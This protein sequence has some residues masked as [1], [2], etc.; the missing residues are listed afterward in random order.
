[1]VL[2]NLLKELD[3]TDD[4]A[5]D[6]MTVGMTLKYSNKC[7]LYDEHSNGTDQENT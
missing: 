3:K 5:E 2:G 1:M 6:K 7:F 4:E